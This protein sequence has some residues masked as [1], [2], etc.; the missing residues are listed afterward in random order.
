MPSLERAI[1]DDGQVPERFN[2]EVAFPESDRWDALAKYEAERWPEI[3]DLTP[4]QHREIYQPYDDRSVFVSVSFRGKDPDRPAALSRLILPKLATTFRDIGTLTMHDVIQGSVI[5]EWGSLHISDEGQGI[6]DTYDPRLSTDVATH[7]SDY[8]VATPWLESMSLGLTNAHAEFQIQDNFDGANPIEP[9]KL[10]A[11]PVMVTDLVQIYL[12]RLKQR[13][14]FM[15]A[16]PSEGSVPIVGV[17]E[18]GDA[19][20]YGEEKRHLWVTAVAVPTNRVVEADT[21]NR[22]RKRLGRTCIPEIFMRVCPE[23][24][25]RYTNLQEAVRAP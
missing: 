24:A 6:L 2:F 19:Q 22:L 15:P 4:E 9:S 7:F 17:Q 12:D 25:E 14:N 11:G 3:F 1:Q 10:E 18:L 13:W 20:P 8:P 5:P 21:A 23:F 16:D